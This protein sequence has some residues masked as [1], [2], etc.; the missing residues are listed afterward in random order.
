MNALTAVPDSI[1]VSSSKQSTASPLDG[2][3]TR[4]KDQSSRRSGL[5]LNGH[6]VIFSVAA[7]LGLAT[8]AECHSV[9]SSS[10]APLWSGALALVGLHRE[11]HVE[12][13]PAAAVCIELLGEGHF[14][15]SAGGVGAWRSPSYA[16]G[17][18]RYDRA[19]MAKP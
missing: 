4:V 11:R 5:R 12:G 13:E 9:T 18:P 6:A 16:A 7:V 15:S 3:S 17:Q 19:G 1:Q 14:D 10:F 2:D 8:A